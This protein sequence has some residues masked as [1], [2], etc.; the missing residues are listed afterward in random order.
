MGQFVNSYQTPEE[1]RK[2]YKLLV[3]HG[4]S[5]QEASRCRDWTLGHINKIMIPF[6]V[7]RN[8]KELQNANPID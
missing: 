4:A 8:L 3:E 6:L 7:E 5:W 2:K 1:R